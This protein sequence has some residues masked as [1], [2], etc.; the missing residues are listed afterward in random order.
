MRASRV[1][2]T[3]VLSLGFLSN[4]AS[5]G[6]AEPPQSGRPFTS[7]SGAFFALS[8]ADLAA[9]TKWYA[10]KF[11][12]AIKTQMPKQNGVAV[13]ILEGG[14]LTVELIQR[15][16]DVPQQTP[17][18]NRVHGI[19]KVGFVVENLTATLT[20]LRSR[21]VVVAYGPYPASS[22]ASANVIV[23]DNAGNLIQLFGR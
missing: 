8:V 12:L 22:N 14:G 3:A 16:N 18:A 11:G 20:S 9:S 17:D 4:G 23:K 15:D 2:A 5:S 10:E 19:F 21:G 1:V 7:I 13:A 6:A